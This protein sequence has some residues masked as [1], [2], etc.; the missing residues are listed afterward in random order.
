MTGG[1]ERG[2]DPRVDEIP[3]QSSEQV[4]RGGRFWFL[5]A[6]RQAPEVSGRNRA[7]C[8]YFQVHPI[9]RLFSVETK[10]PQAVAVSLA[11]VM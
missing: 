1:R 7:V 6:Q 8:S 10:M 4:P 9:L 11:D 2:K 5:P 3:V